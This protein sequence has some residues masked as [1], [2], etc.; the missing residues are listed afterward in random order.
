M[1]NLTEDVTDA[2]LNAL[3][4]VLRP[5]LNDYVSQLCGVL[6]VVDILGLCL[7]VKA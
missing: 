4:P 5:L 7:N 2:L 6:R 1:L 3:D